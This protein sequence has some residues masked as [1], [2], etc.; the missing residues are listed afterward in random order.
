MST[1][2]PVY[3]VS[4][5]DP[6]LV[7]QELSALIA[8]LEPLVGGPGVLEEYGEPGKDEGLAL[9]PVLDACTTPPFLAERRLVVC[10]SASAPDAAQVRE[11]L[12]YLAA[13]LE[14]TVLVLAF[15]GRV[16]AALAKSVKAAGELIDT[17]P[18]S[19]S[20]ARSGWFAEHLAGAPVHLDAAATARLSEH[21][22]EDLSRLSG[23]LDQL[24]A[25]H[26]E[27]AR[28]GTGELEPFLGQ[29]GGAAPWDLT[30][31]LDK[32]ET[33]AALTV[34]RRLL[35]AGGRHP[36]QVLSTLHR[37]YGAML[38]LDGAGIADEQGAAALTGLHPF[39]AKKAL[40]QSRRLGHAGVARAIAL[41][42]SADLDLRGLIGWPGELV[43][44]V[45][46]AR[47][48]QL[49][50]RPATRPARAAR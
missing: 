45:L 12:A 10:R 50:R 43:L 26:G 41:L 37:H 44:E 16:P 2:R 1:P 6:G 22:G 29:A 47:L 35:E 32:G 27:G 23:I 14:T 36:L 24:A 34:L 31:A 46:V 21:L 30:E 9:G 3:L 38:R 5:A 25:A 48:A 28:I 13:P 49:S 15:V 11:L 7:S 18:G 33:E 19:G 39:P 40:E 8:R 42:A 20:R 17:D 4:G